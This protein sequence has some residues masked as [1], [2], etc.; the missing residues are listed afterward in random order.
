MTTSSLPM[1]SPAPAEH[2]DPLSDGRAFRRALG[3]FATGVTVIAT[4]HEGEQVGMTANSFSAL[5]LEPPLI[6]WSIRKESGSL[7]AF[8]QSGHFTVNVLADHQIDTSALFA[9]A[10]DGQMA[11]AD[12]TAG[13]LGDPLL[14]GAVAHFECVTESVTEGG[15]HLILLG[16]VQR[17]ARFDEAPL[18]FAQGQ[19]GSFRRHP[20]LDA[21]PAPAEVSD[22]ATIEESLF[23]SL[24]KATDQRMSTLFDEHRRTLGVTVASGRV[25]NRLALGPRSLL[26][27]EEEAFIGENAAEDALAALAEGGHVRAEPD[28]L[29]TLTDHGRE[30]RAALRRSAETFTSEQLRGIPQEDIAAAERVLGALLAR[31]EHARG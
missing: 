27:I 16:R 21:G 9:R 2:G 3:Q 24:L 6:L 5:S 22:G 28:G 30:L 29:W 12:W 23:M 19:Y 4:S 26:Q 25:L 13:A 15:D 31:N 14:N 7:T 17:F 8:T 10:H 20:E 1:R 18:L 11:Q